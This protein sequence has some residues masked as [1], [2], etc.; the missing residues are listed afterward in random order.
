VVRND[1]P[2]R[3]DESDEALILRAGAG[4]RAACQRLVE[5]HLGRMVAFTQRTLGNRSD[6][7]DAAQDVFLRVWSAAGSW[8]LGH[9]RFTTWL[10]RV[11]MNVCLDRIAKKRETTGEDLPEPADPRPGP[12]DVAHASE[13]AGHVRGALAALP[14]TQRIAV[15]LCHYQGLRNVEAAEVMGVSVEALESLLAR[16]RRT[17]HARLL[18][19]APSLLGNG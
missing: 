12:S 13:V 9:A 10:Y 8:K 7:E 4:D 16:G 17:L 3:A 14:E 6:A 19:L 5:R 11:A 2:R 15:T 1:V 18:P